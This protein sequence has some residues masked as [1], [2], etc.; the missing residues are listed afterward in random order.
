MIKVIPL[1]R[2]PKNQ[3]SQGAT[4]RRIQF[5][6]TTAKAGKQQ[7]YH[8]IV[9]QL[10]ETFKGE[11][12]LIATRCSGVLVRGRSPVHYDRGQVLEFTELGGIIHISKMVLSALFKTGTFTKRPQVLGQV[13]STH[14]V[15]RK[16]PLDFI[17]KPRRT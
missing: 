3:R 1:S 7:F 16:D 10:T 4:F 6:R 13:A 17:V 15:W 11:L 5:K 12:I 9:E 2:I 8:C 14:T